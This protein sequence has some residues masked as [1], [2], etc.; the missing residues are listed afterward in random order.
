MRKNR[1]AAQLRRMRAQFS[2][3]QQPASESQQETQLPAD[4][5][6]VPTAE[7]STSDPV[8]SPSPAGRQSAEPAG[9]IPSQPAPGPDG[10][11]AAAAYSDVEMEE[12][13]CSVPADTDCPEAGAEEET[14]APRLGGLHQMSESA[15]LVTGG[16]GTER[17]A[18]TERE[19]TETVTIAEDQET[20]VARAGHLHLMSEP[21][22]AETED[23]PE[24]AAIVIPDD[25]EPETVT[26]AGNRE[27]EPIV[28]PDD[29]GTDVIMIA[30]DEAEAV[31]V[32]D[33]VDT[34]AV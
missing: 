25:V 34:E 23:G 17:S 20:S 13:H 29:R 10:D 1:E 22:P 12:A 28:I 31:T 21:A 8:L 3:Q 33:D 27:T 15:P 5:G 4:A 26:A 18:V 2:R 19:Q 30:D 16:T 11:A 9:T 14:S 24:T 32:A 6:V 7:G